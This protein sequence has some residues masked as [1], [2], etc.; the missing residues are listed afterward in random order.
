MRSLFLIFL[1]FF[2]ITCAEDSS[3]QKKG[4]I[5]DIRYVQNIGEDEEA[6][7]D[8]MARIDTSA[9]GELL[10]LPTPS[11]AIEKQVFTQQSLLKP[12]GL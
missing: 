11:S 1:A 6:I 5:F 9:I 10:S 3:E 4:R 8:N 2:V 12:E 7:A